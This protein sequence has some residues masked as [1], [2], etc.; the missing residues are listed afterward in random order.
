VRRIPR[1]VITALIAIAVFYGL[2]GIDI[3]CTPV[4]AQSRLSL[5]T[6]AADVDAL[7]AEVS[8]LQC[9]NFSR[10]QLVGFTAANLTGGQ[11]VLAFNAACQAE[12][13][14]SRFCSS[15]EVMES[16]HATPALTGTAWVRPI[17]VGEQT[18][19]GVVV[20]ASGVGGGSSDLSCNGWNTA[21]GGIGLTVDAQGRFSAIGPCTAARPI[22]CCA[23]VPD[24]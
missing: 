20:E 6:V 14:G 8:E 4:G 5:S 11:G 15:V 18:G 21:L 7:A 23:R 1:S 9:A 10:Y 13:A 22:A 12:F 24:H 16:V 19:A 2:L 17:V 3:Q